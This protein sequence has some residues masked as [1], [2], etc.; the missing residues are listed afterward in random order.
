MQKTT[1][2]TL[3]VFFV[4]FIWGVEF[5][6]VHNAI[7]VIEPHSFNFIRFGVASLFVL[8]CMLLWRE[9]EKPSLKLLAQGA[10]LGLL[11]FL[12]FTTQTFGLLYTTVSN[13]GFITSLNVVLVPF[14][15][16]FFLNERPQLHTAVGILTATTGLY[17]LTAAGATPFNIGDLLTLLCASMFAL[18]IVFT[19][20]HA[21]RHKALPLTL[22]Q[23]LTVSVL[24]LA[25]ALIWE[26]WRQMLQPAIIGDP[27]VMSAILIAAILGTGLA[28]LVQTLAQGHL[29]ATRVALIYTS[30]PVFAAIAA[31]LFLNERLLAAA[32]VGAIMILAGII[33]AEQP[34]NPIKG[35]NPLES[36]E[37]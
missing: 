34:W 13:C 19:G 18:H 27:D 22:V 23:L 37:E 20:K 10:F 9:F 33:L 14:F 29:S 25:S 6:L 15:A 21:P 7:A 30:E 5:V 11:L 4:S 2:A 28:L 1:L 31:Y 17:L 26:D 35:V 8:L 32:C 36:G 12:G 3:A 24:S 16:L